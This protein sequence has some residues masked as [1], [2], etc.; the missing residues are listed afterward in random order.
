[1]SQPGGSQRLSFGHDPT[2][3]VT[4]GEWDRDGQE[5]EWGVAVLLRLWPSQRGDN[6]RRISPPTP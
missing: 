1:M 6:K 3:A 2:L 5:K 4:L